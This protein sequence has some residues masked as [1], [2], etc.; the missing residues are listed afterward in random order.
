MDY[1]LG[2]IV[3][4]PYNYAPKHFIKCDGLEMEVQPN[5]ALFSLLG[6]KFGGDGTEFFHLPKM[7]DPCEGISYYICIA[8]IYPPR[9]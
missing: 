3:A 6:T 8:G 2:Q 7:E 4:F 5:Q 9:N 1:Y